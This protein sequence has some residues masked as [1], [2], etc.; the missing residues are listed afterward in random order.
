MSAR[1]IAIGDPHFKVDNIK[2]VE[3]FIDKIELLAKKEEPDAIICLGDLL[4]THER[5]HT[6]AMNKAV[7]FIRRMSAIAPMFVLVGNHDYI[8]NQQF[9]TDNHWMN[10]LKEWD[11]V[12]IVDRVVHR[13]ING[14]NFIF[15]PYV[16]PGRF[17]EALDTSRSEWKSN[18]KC[19]F[20]HQEFYG[21]KMGA[22]ISEDGDKWCEEWPDVISGHVHER[23]TPQPNVYYT[24]SSLQHAFGESDTSTV[25]ILTFDDEPGY[26]LNEIDLGLPRKKIVHMDMDKLESS[27]T[28]D[29]SSE[30]DHIKITV[31]GDYNEFKAFKKTVK[32]RDLVKSGVKIVFKTKAKHGESS[33]VECDFATILKNL[34]DKCPVNLHHMYEHVLSGKDM[35]T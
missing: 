25:A 18:I 16:P 7:E 17:V 24:G 30:K 14:H 2:E 32:Y 34:I 35:N 12:V 10:G 15:V 27:K 11:D 28:C 4:H 26:E 1:I 8:Q 23:Q 3:L 19:I 20:A 22:L 5:V 21:C 9:L 31:E 13:E 33:I 29:L 6:L